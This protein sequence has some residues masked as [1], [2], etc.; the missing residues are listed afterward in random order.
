MEYRVEELGTAAGLPVDTIRFY[1]ARGL[2]PPPRRSGR[3]AVYDE[4]HLERL[5]RIR[6]LLGEGLSLAL[7]KRVLEAPPTA[8]PLLAALVEAQQGERTFSRAELAREAGIP[9]PLIQ[10]A[11]A[12][13]LVEPM[14]VGG[15]ERFGDADLQM[16]RAGMAIL[17][18]GFPLGDLL[19]LAVD[20]ARSVQE[21]SERAIDLFDRFVRRG[22]EDE[23]RSREITSAF[24]QLLPAVTKLVALHFQRTLVNRAIARLEGR[25]EDG[26][27][28]EAIAAVE[29]AR[30]EVAWR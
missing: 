11:Q 9:E 4:A 19:G 26:A 20:H 17:A 6:G 25:G 7:I 27:L 10:A 14:R 3:T 28:G 29:S 13:G 30:L 21:V 18:A 2:L 8:A 24:Q 12:A 1:Q 22:G 5:R 15:E 16:A 23:G